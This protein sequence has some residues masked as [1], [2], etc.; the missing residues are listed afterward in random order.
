MI[1]IF[2]QPSFCCLKGF[3]RLEVSN[4]SV[5]LYA[6][7]LCVKTLDSISLRGEMHNYFPFIRKKLKSQ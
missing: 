7:V 5:T 4:V 1:I 2:G 6:N 3:T